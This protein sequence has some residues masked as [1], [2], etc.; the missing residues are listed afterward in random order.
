LAEHSIESEHQLLFG[1]TTTIATTA[2]YFPR[3]YRETLIIQKHSDNLNRD[4]GYNMG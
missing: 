2:S 3:K 4:V 1:K